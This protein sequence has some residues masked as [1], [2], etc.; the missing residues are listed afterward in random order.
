MKLI[1]VAGPYRAKTPYA[2]LLNIQRAQYAAMEVWETGNAALCPHLNSAFF[3]GLVDDKN[4]LDG[5][6]MMMERCDAV[7][8][9]EGY[10]SSE[11]TKAEINYAKELAIPVFS[12]LEE[13]IDYKWYEQS[14]DKWFCD[15]CKDKVSVHVANSGKVACDVCNSEGLVPF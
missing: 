9:M 13:L 12:S 14:V 1:Y 11:G 2:M 7:L 3:D 6:M 10:D 15:V 5:T 4:F 8:V